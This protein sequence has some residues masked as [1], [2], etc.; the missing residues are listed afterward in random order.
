M[1]ACM[2]SV[3]QEG[4]LFEGDSRVSECLFSFITSLQGNK[5]S[6]R[7]GLVYLYLDV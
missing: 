7:I 3:K 2:N 4:Q 6:V 5:A 1:I